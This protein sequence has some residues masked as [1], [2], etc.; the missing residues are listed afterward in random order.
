MKQWIL[1]GA[2]A[3]AGVSGA[4]MAQDE[5][6][7]NEME[8]F[9]SELTFEQ[10]TVP[11]RE[12]GATLEVAEGFHFLGPK[13][14]QRVLEEAWGNPPD[15]SVLGLLVPDD[16]DLLSEHSWAVVVTY[17]EDG[18]VS[19]ED[20]REIDYDEILADMQSATEDENDAR[21]QEGY[22]QL[23]LKGWAA[24]P[25]YDAVG[26]RLHWAKNLEVEGGDYNAL[27]YDIR[28][29]GRE[30]YLSLN[31][32]ASMDDLALVKS[33]MER[34]LP[35]ANFDEG[36]RYADYREGDKTAAYGLAALVAGGV[37]AKAGLFGKL[38]VLLLSM[39]K[40][41]VFVFIGIA[42][43]FKKI[44]GLF[45]KKEQGTVS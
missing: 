42:A 17:S 1:A 36:H 35:M 5:E 18:Y 21:K 44:V 25:T 7:G 45:K 22:P 27:N 12:A 20:A 2:L 15:D 40:L 6:G 31:A 9:V 8:Q 30:G 29:L 43:G 38:G 34:V 10:G 11:I 37:A 23:H 13:D 19:D 33:G 28:V 32:V 4:A 41:L 26:K 39:K 14:A 16:A 24:P 3:L